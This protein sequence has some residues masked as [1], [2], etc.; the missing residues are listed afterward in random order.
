MKKS[1]I[2]AVSMEKCKSYKKVK[3]WITSSS[4]NFKPRL[5]AISTVVEYIIHI[6]YTTNKQ[7]N[8]NT[9]Q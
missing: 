7:T 6:G 3:S 8:N 5:N 4:Q 9:T 1:K 2:R